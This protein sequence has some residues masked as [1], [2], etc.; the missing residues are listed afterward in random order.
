[1]WT[2]QYPPL[3]K[4]PGEHQLDIVLGPDGGGHITQWDPSG[5]PGDSKQPCRGA[6]DPSI[7]LGSP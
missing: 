7:M 6:E 2:H 1:M 4:A 3:S 5:P